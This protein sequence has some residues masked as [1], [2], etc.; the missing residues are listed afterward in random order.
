MSVDPIHEI[1]SIEQIKQ[2]K[3]RYFRFMDTK[4]WDGL[5]SVFCKDAIFDATHAMD[6]ARITGGAAMDSSQWLAS[7]RDAIVAFISGTSGN[8][9]TVHHGHGHEIQIL[10]DDTAEGIIAMY[11]HN[12]YVDAE[13]R[14]SGEMLGYGHYEEEYRHEDGE[15]RIYRSKLTRLRVDFETFK[16]D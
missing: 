5:G 1:R 14:L 2:L 6:C 9:S 11:D 15:W 13:G 3:S 10:S 4:N 7:G 12:R 16:N 8:A